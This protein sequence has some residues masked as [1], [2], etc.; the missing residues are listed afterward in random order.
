V[1]PLGP[2]KRL[3]AAASVGQDLRPVRVRAASRAAV[4]AVLACAA[5]SLPVATARAEQS[6]KPA[7]QQLWKAFP[8]DSA[9]RQQQRTQRPAARPA[10][11]PAASAEHRSGWWT[12]ALI[13]CIVAAIAALAAAAVRHLRARKREK[14]AS[15]VLDD[16]I[17]VLP[18]R[19]EAVAQRRFHHAEEGH[20]RESRARLGTLDA[21]TASDVRTEPVDDTAVLKS[22]LVSGKEPKAAAPQTE[23]STAGD[24]VDR[25][26]TKLREKPDARLKAE[27]ERSN[28]DDE[29]AAKLR[30]GGPAEKRLKA[31]QPASAI[32]KKEVSPSR[33][34]ARET[35]PLVVI[36]SA[37]A[38]AK[39]QR[40]PQANAR[41]R[42]SDRVCTIRHWRGYVKSMFYA[43]AEDGEDVVAE[44]HP[45]RSLGG[46]LADSDGAVAAHRELVARLEDDGWVA[47]GKGEEWYEV[48]FRRPAV[49]AES[50]AA[51]ARR[52]EREEH[53]V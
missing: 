39:A 50:A 7:P 1:Y 51:G 19:F 40:Q 4:C 52:L 18:G 21:W 34:P 44:S 13:A 16:L 5:L 14:G 9:G 46:R 6:P 31:P 24:D 2:G 8:L 30:R 47:A 41:R 37:P 32:P 45:F 3:R 10:K 23:A 53:H 17:E 27:G 22:K 42:P 20:E 29:L 26:K 15:D 35:P 48:R 12:L 11:T 28:A 33:A 38:P 49:P 43:A 25:L 36:P